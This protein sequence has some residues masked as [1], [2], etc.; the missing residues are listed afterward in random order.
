M[1]DVEFRPV[2]ADDVRYV[3]KHIAGDNERELLATGMTK[4]YFEYDFLKGLKKSTYTCGMWVDGR[5]QMVSGVVPDF[6]DGKR[7]VLWLIFTQEC[8]ERFWV[9]IARYSKMVLG[10]YLRRFDA[11]YNWVNADNV[12]IRRWHR[13]MGYRETYVGKVGC[14]GVE[15]Y[16]YEISG[17]RYEGQGTRYKGK[18]SG[19]RNKE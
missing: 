3:V 9:K 6:L 12:K 5:C 4:K 13:W 14:F 17:T 7:G 11:V 1:A 16:Y 18:G 15:H 8:K 2:T 19:I 10:C